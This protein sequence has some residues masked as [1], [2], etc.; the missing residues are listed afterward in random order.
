M[1]EHHDCNKNPVPLDHDEKRGRPFLFSGMSDKSRLRVNMTNFLRGLLALCLAYTVLSR[2]FP[3]GPQQVL[4]EGAP[5]LLQ[6]NV[7]APP[8]PGL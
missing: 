7:C 1:I 4:V 8:S 6:P 5:K 2:A 3:A